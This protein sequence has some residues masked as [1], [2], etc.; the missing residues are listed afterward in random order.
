MEVSTDKPTESGE[1]KQFDMP[2]YPSQRVEEREPRK[3]LEEKK[4]TL[5][6]QD[7]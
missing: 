2:K 1:Q 6:V 5:T 4:M 7:R 3:S